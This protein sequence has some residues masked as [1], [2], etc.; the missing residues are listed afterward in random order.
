[1][2][3]RDYVRRSLRIRANVCMEQ[4]IASLMDEDFH[5]ETVY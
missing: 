4:C 3:W 2:D 5:Y 1:M